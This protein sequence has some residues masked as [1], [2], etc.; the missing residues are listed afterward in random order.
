LGANHPVKINVRVIAATNRDLPDACRQERF[1]WDL[2]YRLAVAEL[3]LPDM[4]DMPLSERSA[5]IAFFLKTKKA[6][7]RKSHLL[8]LSKD[9]EAA[10]LAYPFPGNI[11]ELENLIAQLYVFYEEKVELHDLPMR[12]QKPVVENS[13]RWQ[14]V[15]KVHIQKVMRMTNGNKKKACELLGYGSIN[16]LQSR[17][18]LYE[19]EE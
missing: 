4:A 15:E 6:E 3:A 1:R 10:L 11:R 18:R 14:D 9:A 2:Y 17:L 12:L 5:L 16:T 7:L 13:L 8:K 19:L